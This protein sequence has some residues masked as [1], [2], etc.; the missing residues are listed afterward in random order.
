MCM[1]GGKR[2]QQ[3]NC[4]QYCQTGYSIIKHCWP[5]RHHL[6]SFE[7]L[8]GA[9]PRY[10]PENCQ[11]CLIHFGNPTFNWAHI[12]LRATPCS[13]VFGG[14][15]S[16]TVPVTAASNIQNRQSSGKSGQFGNHLENWQSSGKI[17][18]VLKSSGKL[19][20][21]WNIRTVLKSSGKLAVIWKNPDSFEIIRKIGCHL[22]KSGQF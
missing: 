9:E 20:V 16:G 19:A 8:T 14:S 18:T 17:W 11:K 3:T 15:T 1:W 22:E 12:G 2:H 13:R 21:T 6:S 4:M 5:A 10:Q 7:S